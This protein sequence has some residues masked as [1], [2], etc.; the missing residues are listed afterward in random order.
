MQAKM[1]NLAITIEDMGT[2][3]NDSTG[4]RIAWMRKQRRLTGHDLAKAVDVRNVYISQIENGH[5]EA[6][7]QT[8][9]KIAAVLGTTVG[10]LLMETDDPEP[11]N[12]PLVAGPDWSPAADAAAR[13]VN[14]ASLEDQARMLAVLQALAS[15]SE[16]N[17]FQE[18]NRE[19]VI[20]LPNRTA[21]AEPMQGRLILG[22]YFGQ[23][24]QRA[25]P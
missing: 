18:K 25:S 19:G 9:Q 14:E 1:D 3:T 10:F 6:S 8:L 4:A 21:P 2:Y 17:S 15:I 20:Y 13:L 7:R 11:A 12:A 16:A 24:N 23:R 5:R 22:E